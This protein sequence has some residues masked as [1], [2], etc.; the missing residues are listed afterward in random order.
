MKN[1]YIHIMNFDQCLL[2][3]SCLQV[4][5]YC[6]HIP[7]SQL[8]RHLKETLSPFVAS[9]MSTG[10]GFQSGQGQPLGGH[11]PEEKELFFPWQPS[12]VNM[13]QIMIEHD[14]A[15]HHLPGIL[16][17]LILCMS[18]TWQLHILWVQVYSDPM[19]RIHHLLLTVTIT[20]S[21]NLSSP[22]S[23]REKV[24]F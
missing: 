22:C 24:W 7:H 14:E 19:S 23:L 10:I 3:A 1:L 20:G 12:V 2:P 11:I 9:C 6:T 16:I 4:F 15:F 21:N 5:P 8:H 13:S 18:L 17:R